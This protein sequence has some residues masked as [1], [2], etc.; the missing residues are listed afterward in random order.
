MLQVDEDKFIELI[1]RYAVEIYEVST[2]FG[3]GRSL[4]VNDIQQDIVSHLFEEYQRYG[5]ARCQNPN[6]ERNW[7]RQIALHV[8][9]NYSAQYQGK[10]PVSSLTEADFEI[11]LT[12]EELQTKEYLEEVL[13]NLDLK[14]KRMMLYLLN[15]Y[16][17]QQIADSEHISETAVGTRMSRIY[18]KL[19]TIL[20]K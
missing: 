16:S 11:A 5:F 2:L 8:A 13:D 3:L 19:R 12:D 15:Q 18:K 9:M 17:Y 14:E 10:L 6:S 1:N 4:Y 20:K 7:V